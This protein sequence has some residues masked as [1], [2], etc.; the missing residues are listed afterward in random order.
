MNGMSK[1]LLA[2]VLASTLAA[3]NNGDD[4]PEQRCETPTAVNPPINQEFNVRVGGTVTVDGG[5]QLQF[6]AVDGASRCPS[7]VQCI[8][9]GSVILSMVGQATGRDAKPFTLETGAD[10]SETFEFT[11][12]FYDLQLNSVNPYPISASTIAPDG[13]CATFTVAKALE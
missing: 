11:G 8:T 13:Y 3:C 10:A 7:D 5:L 1:N 9:A 6:V 4:R 12:G 2:L